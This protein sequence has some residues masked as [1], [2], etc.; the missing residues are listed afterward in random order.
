MSS[1][2]MKAVVFYGPHDVRVEDRPI[3]RLQASTDA[4]LKVSLTALCGSE[5]HVFRGHQ[6][7]E[8]GFIM[9]HEFT[10]E[11]VE[12]GEAVREFTKGDKVV[13]PFTVSC[14][15]CYYCSNGETSRC[16]K[17]LLFGNPK[18][19]GGQAEYV[20]VPLADGTLF[21]APP[22]VPE[23]TLVLMA[24]I[25][26][27]GFFC[28]RNAFASFLASRHASST[29]VLIGCGP[30]G[31]CALVAALDYK[32]KHLFAIDAVPSR[33]EL[34]RSLGAEPLNFKE[35]YEGTKKRI[36]EVTQGR[37]ADVVMEVVGLAPALRTA[38]ELVR[39][40]GFISSVGVHNAEI[41]ISGNEAYA[42]NVRIQF[43]R[44]PVRALFPEALD[45]LKRRSHLFG[46]MADKIMPLE[47]AVEG[48]DLFDQMKVQKV[49][50]KV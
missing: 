8:A 32:P 47:K 26:P 17:C 29:A 28:A 49:V 10:G 33:L 19:D 2:I 41:P 35:D 20:R 21:K 16:D 39:P 1:N 14:G 50:F 18:L 13:S 11:V 5:L 6:K 22:E 42:K 7:T 9:G 4:I 44:C 36:M 15:K 43:G 37:G 45:V 48:Y 23:E 31:L 27:T 30:V 46:F 38:Y 40:F 3:P 25:F 34:A 12:V 24:D